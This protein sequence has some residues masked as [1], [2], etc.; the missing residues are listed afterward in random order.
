MSAAA[1]M[2]TLP[3]ALA[4]AVVQLQ[5]SL[6]APG[7]GRCWGCNQTRPTSMAWRVAAYL[8]RDLRH[9]P[10]AYLLCPSCA[11]SDK[12]RKR[13]ARTI[14]TKARDLAERRAAQ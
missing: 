14:E 2:G 4:A 5:C 7:R 3:P 1:S 9:P 13:A 11:A 6:H 12:A 10:T 8:P